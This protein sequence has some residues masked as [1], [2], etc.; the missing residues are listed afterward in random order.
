MHTW[1]ALHVPE[2]APATQ[3]VPSGRKVAPVQTPTW[4]D[5]VTVQES[6]SLQ[7]APSLFAGLEH[8]PVP[9]LH[10][11]ASWHWSSGVHTTGA[12]LM[13]APFWQASPTVQAF[14]SL[15]DVASGLFPNEHVPLAGLHV[16][17]VWHWLG[18]HVTGLAPVQVPP[19]HVSVIVQALP[20]LHIVPSALLGYEQTPVAGTHVPA[21]WH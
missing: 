3:A 8:M 19:W 15:H 10:V 11:P 20:S 16:P 21:L 18:V 2:M 17:P 9:M 5:S 6:L 13:H 7:T 12:P 4:Q 14:R 1:T